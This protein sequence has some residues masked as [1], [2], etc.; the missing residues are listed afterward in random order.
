MDHN[1]SPGIL[2][3]SPRLRRLF[4]ELAEESAGSFKPATP[5]PPLLTDLALIVG[6]EANRV[7]G[8]FCLHPDITA[9]LDETCPGAYALVEHLEPSETEQPHAPLVCALRLP[10]AAA[11]LFRLRWR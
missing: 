11:L 3:A 7:E 6:L 1:I 9:W 8:D 2:R 4:A 10:D 5:C